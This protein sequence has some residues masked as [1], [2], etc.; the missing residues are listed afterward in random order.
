MHRQ[1]MHSNFNITNFEEIVKKIHIWFDTA[2]GFEQHV[3]LSNLKKKLIAVRNRDA[4]LLY[5]ASYDIEC[6]ITDLAT[7][8]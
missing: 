8:L 5:L 6:L 1:G 7:L 3:S 4:T 2:T